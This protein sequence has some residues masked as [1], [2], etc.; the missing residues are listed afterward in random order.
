M[1]KYY[2]D[3]CGED[4]TNQINGCL[5]L[6][7]TLSLKTPILNKK[8]YNYTLCSKCFQEMSNFLDKAVKNK[9]VLNNDR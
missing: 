7:R 2:C 9:G 5:K 6:Q 1:I 8:Q 3:I 4:I